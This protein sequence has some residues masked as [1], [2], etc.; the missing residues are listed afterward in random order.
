[1]SERYV[2]QAPRGDERIVN[3][4]RRASAAAWL[5][6]VLL[7]Q[8]VLALG[9]HEI[10]VLVND[11]SP[12]SL[13]VANHFIRLRR[14]PA[15]NVVHLNLPQHARSPRTGISREDFTRLIWEPASAAVRERGLADHLLAWIYSAD[16]PLRVEGDPDLSLSG[17]TFVR[18][19]APDPDAVRA[20]RVV[21][22]LFAGPGQG[23]A[24]KA[25]TRTLAD[26]A[27]VLQTNMPL[28][29]MS[30]AHTGSR[31]TTVDQAVTLLRQAAATDATMPDGEIVF[32]AGDDVRA[33]SRNW[34]FDGVVEELKQLGVRSRVTSNA[35]GPPH[36]LL[37]IMMGTTHVDPPR[38]GVLVPGSMADHLT[39]F[40]GDFGSASQTKM[41]AWL[42]AGATASAGTVTEP[43][44]LWPKFPH[45]RFY[46]HY[47][48]GCSMIEAFFQSLASPLQ[49][50]LIGDPLARPWGRPPGVTLVDLSEGAQ[51][52]EKIDFLA[53][54][55]TSPF[56]PPPITFFLLDGRSVPAPPDKA[57]LSLNARLLGD[58]YH[59]LRAVAYARTGVRQQG[60]DVR[61]F[62]VNLRGRA[63]RLAG[64]ADNATV[65]LDHPLALR[66]EA[67]GEP[68]E[69]ALLS[70]GR[71]LARQP[72]GAAP[73][74]TLDPRQLGAGPNALQAAAWYDDGAPVR[75]APVS[76]RVERLNKFPEIATLVRTNIEGGGWSLAV[77]ARDPEQDP[78]TVTWWQDVRAGTAPPD[79]QG[80]SCVW[81]NDAWELSA[82][83]PVVTA[84]APATRGCAVEEI[85]VEVRVPGADQ[86]MTGQMAGV[87][88][89]YRDPS[90]FSFFGW[91]GHNSSWTLGVYED[92]ALRQ[93]TAVGA[94]IEPGRWHRLRVRTTQEQSVEALV[95]DEV[96]ARM[97]YD[98][99]LGPAGLAARTDP[100]LARALRVSPP[101]YPAGE[102]RLDGE[103]AQLAHDVLPEGLAVRAADRIGGFI[104]PV[105]ALP[106]GAQ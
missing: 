11:A 64:L 82:T 96:L 70:Q 9:P 71:V 93:E 6:F 43:F 90:Q 3:R 87:V 101:C 85:S 42:R 18:N 16:F 31:G 51:G 88:F 53:S 102:F 92:G 29:S 77:Q 35:P 46:A 66:V 76:L 15:E 21:S 22:R 100:A 2:R 106:G 83:G 1:M 55:W 67:E 86:A 65:D 23:D 49:I 81:T 30:L 69:V 54:A 25:P 73:A 58:G 80:G 32:I 50:Q 97:P 13:E 75:S 99:A 45:A 37:G 44:A 61:G 24:R 10:L 62:T 19:Q 52:L 94:Y 8:G 103:R 12:R 74:F 68:R 47:A 39:S 17:L 84:V 40:A 79:V 78:V 20:G 104:E 89:A 57:Q 33:T 105:R 41:T 63:V 34:Q 91:L 56:E 38:V 60:F 95:D 26:Y 72:Y 27:A 5:A 98:R 7:A 36:R 4:N 28:A 59:E 14:V 48:A